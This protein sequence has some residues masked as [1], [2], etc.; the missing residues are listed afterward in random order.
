METTSAIQSVLYIGVLF[1]IFYFLI[2]R[3]QQKQRKKH[4][5]LM[6]SLVSGDEVVTA[7][8]IHGTIKSVREDTLDIEVASGIVLKISRG[9]VSQKA[10][11]E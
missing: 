7:G 10:D 4:K 11:E 3:P 9:A 5:D 1:G 2:I 8:G 6:D